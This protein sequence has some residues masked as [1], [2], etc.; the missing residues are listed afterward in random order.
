MRHRPIAPRWTRR[1][2]RRRV[3]RSILL[4][5][6]IAAGAAAGAVWL[7]GRELAEGLVHVGLARAGIPWQGV[8]VRSIGFGG[9]GPGPSQ[10][11]GAGGPAA[12]A[13]GSAWTGGSL[14]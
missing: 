14:G 6:L 13:I 8:A 1:E 9:M 7:R 5:C 3:L 12:A 2:R 10:L 11:G 4:V